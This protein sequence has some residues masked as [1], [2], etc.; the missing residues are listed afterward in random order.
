MYLLYLIVQYFLHVC[1]NSIETCLVSQS[2]IQ[3][4]VTVLYCSCIGV[5]TITVLL[6]YIDTSKWIDWEPKR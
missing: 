2:F 6:Q 5:G 3:K 1:C 4:I